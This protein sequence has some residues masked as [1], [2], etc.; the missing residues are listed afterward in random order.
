MD[1]IAQNQLVA[2]AAP[3]IPL[4]DWCEVT[5]AD[6]RPDATET[7]CARILEAVGLPCF[8]KPANLGSS[9]GVV[10]VTDAAALPDALATAA[11]YDHRVIVEAGVD[12]REVEL[13]VL[14]N[15]DDDLVVSAPGEIELP[16]GVWYDYETKYEKDVATY[17][18]P[19]SLPEDVAERSDR[20]VLEILRHLVL[21]EQHLGILAVTRS[22]SEIGRILFALFGPVKV[23]VVAHLHRNAE[24][25]L[26]Y[27]AEHFLIK[28][29]G[30][31]FVPSHVR[32]G[33]RILGFEILDDLGVLRRVPVTHPGVIVG[34]LIAMDLEDLGFL[35]GHRRLYRFLG[36]A[37]SYA[38]NDC[39]KRRDKAKRSFHRAV[40]LK[41]LKLTFI[42]TKY[43]N[44]RFLFGQCYLNRFN[45]MTV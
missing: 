44:W 4:V 38:H 43:F 23:P 24:I 13:A 45:S 37:H 16:A 11:T 20:E 42:L 29:F 41:V 31:L 19:A 30:K 36:S 33:V 21:V 3:D 26:L 35:F 2:A 14:G 9:V 8:V 22:A 32:F 17:H 7:T 27:A 25:G 40:L 5:P 12:A 10:K 28:V 39:N 18:I 34:D 6:L 15:D 1:N